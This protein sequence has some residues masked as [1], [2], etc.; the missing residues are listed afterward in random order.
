MS[1]PKKMRV[2]FIHPFLFRYARGIER[3]TINLANALA[4]R[5]VEVHLLTWRW[6]HPLK[7]DSLEPRV[8]IH[9]LPTSRYYAAKAIVPFYIWELLRGQYDFVWVFFA[10]YGEAA[11]ITAASRLRPISYGVILHYPLTQVPHRYEELKR[12]GFAKK[13]HTIVATSGFV[14]EGVRRALNRESVIITSGVAVNRFRPDHALR[15][16]QRSSLGLGADD[17]VLLTVAALEERKGIQYVLQVLP[18]VLAQHPKVKYI[19]AGEGLY[20][21]A[22][23]AQIRNNSLGGVVRLVGAE[24]DIFPYYNIADVF[25]LLAHGEASPLAP[26]EALAMELPVIVSTQPPFDEIVRPEFG[27]MVRETDTKAVVDSV[28]ALL[29]NPGR[30]RSMGYAGRVHV[31]ERYGWPAIAEQYLSLLNV[32]K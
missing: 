14:A 1:E 25:L 10:G 27:I 13:A 32:R 4:R 16:Q 30:R 19:V 9:L 5:G 18:A 31:Q 24:E 22:L 7:I 8:K 11:A 28:N 15:Q 23:E 21:S 12:F 20:R 6:P 3:F 2:A 29:D 26:L 17:Q